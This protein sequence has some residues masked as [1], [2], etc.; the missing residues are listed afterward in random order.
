VIEYAAVNESGDL[1]KL[2]IQRTFKSIVIIESPV[3]ANRQMEISRWL[4]HQ[5]CL[6]MM[7]W[8][9]G[10]SSWD[11]SVDIANLMD[12][13]FGDIPDDKSV[14][15]T[16]H[17][18]ELLTEVFHF[19]KYMTVYSSPQ[20]EDTLILHINGADGEAMFSQMYLEA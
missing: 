20:L 4:V 3:T 18:D 15:T 17:D 12:Y 16:W 13:G 8:G 5:G 11:D 6:Y 14:M 1:P 19:A 9:P 10:C 7:A 2:N